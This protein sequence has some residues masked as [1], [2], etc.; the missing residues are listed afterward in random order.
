MIYKNTLFPP[1]FNFNHDQ[2]FQ[3]TFYI[4]Y[5]NDNGHKKLT[6]QNLS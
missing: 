4:M 1:N 3:N 6:L 2:L 5:F